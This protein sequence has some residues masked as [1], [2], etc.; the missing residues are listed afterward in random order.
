MCMHTQEQV[1]YML[2]WYS[3]ALSAWV[4]SIVGDPGVK[5]DNKSLKGE[6]HI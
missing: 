2:K 1:Q 3:E 6:F 4:A 5:I